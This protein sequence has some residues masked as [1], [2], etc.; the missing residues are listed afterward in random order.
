MERPYLDLR[1]TITN[2]KPNMQKQNSSKSIA[3]KNSKRLSVQKI[4]FFEIVRK[5]KTSLWK[6][7]ESVL[8]CFW[9][10]V[11]QNALLAALSWTYAIKAWLVLSSTRIKV[12]A[13]RNKRFL[14][15]R[16]HQNIVPS[17]LPWLSGSLAWTPVPPLSKMND[18]IKST[19]CCQNDN[20]N[21]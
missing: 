4:A 18:K 2:W 10:W 19:N 20:C 12:L 16:A 3:Y 21:D 13:W 5:M 17:F 1:N 11:A 7:G 6:N 8:T 14:T 15:L 9:D